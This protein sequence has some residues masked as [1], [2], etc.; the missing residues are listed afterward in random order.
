M[1]TPDRV[2]DVRRA[3]CVHLANVHKPLAE[4]DTDKLTQFLRIVLPN[5]PSGGITHE[6]RAAIQK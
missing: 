6:G 1:F 5:Y 4:N 3:E 2:T